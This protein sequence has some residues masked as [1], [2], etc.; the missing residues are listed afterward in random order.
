MKWF[1]NGEPSEYGG[2]RTKDEI[3]NWINKR[4]GPPSKAVTS[5]ELDSQIENNKLTVV[6]FGADGAEFK[7]FEKAASADDK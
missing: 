4:S 7:E 2:G 6:F 3:V 1:V 5:S